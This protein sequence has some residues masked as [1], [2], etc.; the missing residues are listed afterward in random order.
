MV[1]CLHGI[2]DNCS[3]AWCGFLK[4]PET[5]VPSKLSYKKYLTDAAMKK[6]LEVILC[7][8]SDSADKLSNLG[9]TQ[10]NESLNNTIT[11]KAP[12]STLYSGSES[13]D[14]RVAAAVAQKTWD[15][16]MPV[17]ENEEI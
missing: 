13:N 12:K 16:S 17:R 6:D 10:A 2:H 8:L 9:S 3:S 14:Y 15:T 5:C 7:N 4:S 1:P 11:S